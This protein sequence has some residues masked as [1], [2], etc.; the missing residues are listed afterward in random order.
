MRRTPAVRAS[1]GLSFRSPGLLR[2]PQPISAPG[3][4]SVYSRSVAEATVYGCTFLLATPT[5]EKPSTHY[6]ASCSSL[7]EGKVQ[8]RQT[9]QQT[10]QALCLNLVTNAIV[11]NA[12]IERLRA[13]GRIGR[14]IDLGHLSPAPLRARQSLRQVPIRDRGSSARFP[15][16]KESGKRRLACDSAPLLSEPQPADGLVR[17]L[18]AY[19]PRWA[20]DAGADRGF[21]GLPLGQAK[22]IGR[23]RKSLHLRKANK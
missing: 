3:V 22:M 13:E 17:S 23:T 16:S 1:N 7:T 18:Q 14:D 9:D 4:G 12:A 15:T 19:D 10:N 21:G 5:R 2:S 20:E 11:M 8:R 6:A